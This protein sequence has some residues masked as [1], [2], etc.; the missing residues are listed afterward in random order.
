MRPVTVVVAPEVLDD[1]AGLGKRPK[2]FPVK[3]LVAE[4]AM[5][6]LDEPV[7]PRAG[8]LNIDRLDPVR[9]S[10][11]WTSLAMNSEPLSLRRYSGAP[12]SAMALPI[13]SS[14]SALFNA[15]SALST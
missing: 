8:R 10:Q 6:A 2:L 14:T 13:H 9:S 4:A 7:M 3:T 5:E 12:C 15:R 11:R 1:D